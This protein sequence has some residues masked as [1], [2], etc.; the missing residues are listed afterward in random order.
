[1]SAV[2][3]TGKQA[4]KLTTEQKRRVRE[5]MVDE[6]ESRASAIAWV[7]AFEPSVKS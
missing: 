2:K 4:R 3:S 5:L 7:L 6:G 1:V